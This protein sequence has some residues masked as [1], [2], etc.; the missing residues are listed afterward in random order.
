MANSYSSSFFYRPEST[1]QRGSSPISEPQKQSILDPAKIIAIGIASPLASFLTSRFGV[2]GTVIGL[3]LSAMIL[4]AVADYLKVYLAR[5]SHAAAQAAAHTGTQKAPRRGLLARL[6]GLKGGSG[7]RLKA[8]YRGFYGAPP[9]AWRWVR[10]VGRSVVTAV[11]SFVLALG[12][13]TALEQG[14][15]KIL[16]RSLWEECPAAGAPAEDEGNGTSSNQ[17]STL[18]SMLGGSPS[19]GS[20]ATGIR[21]PAADGGAPEQRSTPDDSGA[22]EPPSSQAS[23]EVA[24]SGG[25]ESE[26]ADQSGQQQSRSYNSEDYE[27]QEASYY[28]S[29]EE[30][31]EPTSSDSS[32]SSS[33]TT[34]EDQPQEEDQNAAPLDMEGKAPEEYAFPSVPWTT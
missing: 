28:Y 16:T 12:A 4:T 9:P 24:G 10:L 20:E 19:A 3:A 31:E 29:S 32:P 23:S 21:I 7:G 27:R 5:A 26:V 18:P 22:P 13:V 25:S 14:V 34:E 2:A 6:F 8:S 1:D 15:G 33:G 17:Q 11:I 30:Y